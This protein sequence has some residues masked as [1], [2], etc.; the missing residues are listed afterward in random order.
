M[1]SY[2]TLALVLAACLASV[3][4]AAGGPQSPQLRAQLDLSFEKADLDHDGYLDAAELAKAFRGPKAKVI[5]HPSLPAGKSPPAEIHADH[6][7]LDA[8]DK[9]RDGRISKAE[10]ERY[11]ARVVADARRLAAERRAA[12]QRLNRGKRR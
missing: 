11:E 2:R 1:R 4:G 12:A 6:L 3:Q 10:F 8:Y 5:E 7:F 9:D